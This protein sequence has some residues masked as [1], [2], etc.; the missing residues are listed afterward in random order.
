[1][2]MMWPPQRVKIT[3]TPSFFRARATRCP[4]EMVP[5]LSVTSFPQSRPYVAAGQI[6]YRGPEAS[7]TDTRL[8]GPRVLASNC[9]AIAPDLDARTLGDGVGGGLGVPHDLVDVERD[10]LATALQHPA[11]DEHGVDVGRGHRADDRRLQVDHRCDVDVMA[12][13]QD[14]V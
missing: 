8:R 2:S 12:A 1:M 10:E 6:V 11:V 14:Q 7:P 13:D 9:G 3:S 4:P 5:S